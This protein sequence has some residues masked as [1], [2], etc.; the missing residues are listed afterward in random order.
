MS[1]KLIDEFVDAKSDKSNEDDR[2]ECVFLKNLNKKDGTLVRVRFLD[3]Q[4]R[5][6]VTMQKKLKKKQSYQ[7]GRVTLTKKYSYQA[8]ES[9]LKRTTP[10]RR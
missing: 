2:Q 6:D 1:Y 10:I 4:R 3:F 7:A 8:V 9:S 5:L